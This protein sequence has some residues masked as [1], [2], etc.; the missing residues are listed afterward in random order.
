MSETL[1]PKA[2]DIPAAQDLG[3]SV[4]HAMDAAIPK[5]DVPIPSA[6]RLAESSSRVWAYNTD[7]AQTH[8]VTDRYLVGHELL[9]GRGKEIELLNRDI[10][11][12]IRQRVPHSVTRI[13]D[14]RVAAVIVQHPV[15][16]RD[17]HGSPLRFRETPANTVSTH[18]DTLHEEVENLNS[19]LAKEEK[20]AKSKR[21]GR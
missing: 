7:L 2:I 13:V 3:F 9:P 15:E 17:E 11:Y 5:G 14:D 18:D 16:L 10:E 1:D 8:I 6:E 19:T 20:V 21:Y 12:F 4:P